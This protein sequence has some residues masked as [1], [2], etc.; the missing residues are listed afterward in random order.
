M[1]EIHNIFTKHR[2]EWTARPLGRY[3]EEL[4]QEFYASYVAT[5]R[6]QVGRQ[7]AHAKQA[8]LE[9]V[10]VRSVQVDISLPAI[11]RFL[12]GESAD[13]TRTPIT[14]EFDYC[15]QIVKDGQLLHEPA[16]R[17]TTKRWMALHLSVDGEGADWVTEPKGAIKKA[18]LTFTAK[19]L[20][21]LVRHCLSPTAADNIVTWDRE[22]LMAVMIVGFEVDFAWLLQA[23][24]HERAFKVT[25]TYPFPCMI[26]SLCRSAS[27][28]IWHVDQLKTPKGIVDI[29]LIRDE[30][31][32]LSP[33][34]GPCPE[35]PPLADDLADTVAQARTAR[36]PLAQ[37]LYRRWSR[38]LG[39]KN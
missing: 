7:A 17:E 25:T 24:M 11:R 29:G 36:A 31:N 3:S 10:L 12:Y 1:P 8:P 18:N 28:P 15:W 39:L 27:V 6:S 9:Q 30:A 35:L 32:E 13:A 34:R 23:V 16:L 4:V 19:F 33:R 37:P 22:V 20:W 5:V 26:F 2:L 21:L 38:L 14:A